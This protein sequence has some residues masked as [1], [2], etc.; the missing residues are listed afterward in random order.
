MIR[1]GL[2][3]VLCS[4][5][6]ATSALAWAPVDRRIDG[7][8]RWDT[9]NPVPWSHD[10]GKLGI[11]GNPTA[12]AEVQG[13]FNV[14]DNVTTAGIDYA[15]QGQ[16]LHPTTLLPIDVTSATYSLVVNANDG[17]NPIVFD[18]NSDIVNA[19]G[20]P[21]GVIA[22]ADIIRNTGTTAT[23]AF[24]LFNGEFFDGDAGDVGELTVNEFRHVLVH[25]LGHFSGLGHSSVNH[26][27]IVGIPGCPPPTAS[28]IEKMTP[29]VPAGAVPDLEY[30]DKVGLSHLYPGAGFN[31][32]FSRVRGKIL[33]ADHV[34][35]RDGANLILRPVIAN[36]DARY[37]GSQSFQAGTNPGEF[38]GQGTYEFPGLSPGQAYT[39][40]ATSILDGGQYPYGAATLGGPIEFY[41]GASEDHFN[42]PDVPSS[43]SSIIA[44]AAGSTLTG[45]DILI[46]APEG[47][48]S[49]DDVGL[50]SLSLLKLD[51]VT[52]LPSELLIVDEEYNE[53]VLPVDPPTTLL[54][55]VNRFTPGA[56]RLPLTIDRLEIY[57]N[58][59]VP[60]TGRSVRI[61]VYSDP[62]GTGDMANA[63]L[64]YQETTVIP[65]EGAGANGY[66]LY[67]L[68][69]PVTI[70]SG[71]FYVGLIDLVSDGAPAFASFDPI[72]QGNAWAAFNSLSPGAFFQVAEGNWYVRARVSTTPPD[73]SLLLTWGDSCNESTVVDQDFVVYEGSLATLH[74]TPDHEPATCSTAGLK[75]WVAVP[76]GGDQFWLVTP[77]VSTREG[78]LGTGTGGSPRTPVSTC[79]TALADSCP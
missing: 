61:L 67:P 76:A 50:D 66:D 72:V 35:P 14:W 12:V 62:A 42:P 16:I 55:W 63:T 20:L 45:I 32:T 54:A 21:Q 37:E 53:G 44:P 15:S 17:Q 70:T 11:W 9:T 78:D 52:T 33:S 3:I 43:A 47:P 71:E 36:C 19:L 26:E 77:R 7:P 10:G 31:S 65:P 51:G 28:Q 46:N 38:G 69:S 48:T 1:R 23:K 56:Q 41:N 79:A 40:L 27:F 74:T 22:S 24:A 60:I 57:V 34:V 30:D 73:D 5:L 29:F 39:L 49:I 2:T 68:A 59:E 64:V 8:L 4:A 75:S 6:L 58:R 13:A 25:E 18:N